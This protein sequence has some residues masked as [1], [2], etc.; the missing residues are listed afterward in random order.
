[1]IEVQD[2]GLKGV[3]PYI[4]HGFFGRNGGVSEGVYGSLNCG[5]GSNDDAK[6]VQQNKALVAEQLSVNKEKLVTISQIHSD[7]CF[8]VD[9]PFDANTEIPEGDALVTDKAGLAI[10]VLTADCAPVLFAGLKVDCHP[11]I[12]AAH[13][14]WGGAIK[15]VCEK[16]VQIML[17]H[18]ADISTI[19]A[20]VGPCINQKSYEVSQD[21]S[22]PFIEQDEANE[23]FFKNANKEGH[24]MFDLPGYIASRLAKIGVK[25]ISITGVDTY[26]E[27]ARFFS[28][29]RKFHRK[30]PDYGRQISAIC[31][32]E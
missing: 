24:L 29:R 9:A 16:T 8:Y 10:G 23:H 4:T 31:I 25:N 11:I 15:G 1:M 20:V 18:G 32:K 13:S 14:G 17:E 30:E 6:K 19:S 7:K 26:S 21:F 12:G 22:V 27:E 2:N 5:I 3:H 28:Y